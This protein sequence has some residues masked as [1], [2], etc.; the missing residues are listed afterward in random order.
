MLNKK[1]SDAEELWEKVIFAKQLMLLT[2]NKI[3]ILLN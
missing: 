3:Q 1:D 2:A